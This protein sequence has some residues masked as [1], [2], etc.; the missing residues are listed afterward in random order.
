M[1]FKIRGYSLQA[2]LELEQ[3]IIGA[4][5]LQSE[6]YVQIGRFLEPKNFLYELNQ[7]IWSA[8]QEMWT[9]TPIDL[10]TVYH[11]LI[12]THD[13]QS[14]DFL[15]PYLTK[16]NNTSNLLYWSVYL[17]EVDIATKSA[18]LIENFN[19]SSIDTQIK[20][21]SEEIYFEI[22]DNSKDLLQTLEDAHEYLI[23]IDPLHEISKEFTHLNETLVKHALKIKGDLPKWQ[24]LDQLKSLG[25]DG[26][27]S[28]QIAVKNLGDIYL[29]VVNSRSISP[30]LLEQIVQLKS[31][32]IL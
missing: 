26:D 25:K 8:F 30:Q 29:S 12:R 10:C 16:V 14:R 22:L 24:L 31:S 21:A 2:R 7:N 19:F 18:K 1:S 15:F 5:L 3:T 27:I 28:K 32:L 4:V 11:H 9:I 17:L 20:E 23:S 13:F 6:V